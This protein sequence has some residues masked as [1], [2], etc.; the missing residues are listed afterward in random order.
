MSVYQARQLRKRMSPPEV[1][2]WH[3][4]KLRPNGLQFR[5][6]HPFGPFIL[7]FFCKAAGL[8]IEVDGMAHGFGENPQRD[9]RRDRWIRAKGVETVRVSAGDVRRNLDGVVVHIVNRCGERTPPPHFVRSPSPS[10]DGE[11]D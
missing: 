6:Q 11:D 10:N 8:A 4:L 2:L 9:E 3:V 1:R 7:D 5:R